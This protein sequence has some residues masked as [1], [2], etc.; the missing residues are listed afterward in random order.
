MN[1]SMIL[2]NSAWAGLFAGTLA[3]LFAS[4]PQYL[5]ATILCGF[6]G[7]CVND[8][9]VAVGL[10]QNLSTAM[11]ACA[12]VLVAAAVTRNHDA[13]PVVL[14]AGVVPLGAALAMFNTI[15]ALMKISSLSGEA[16]NASSVALS[17]NAGKVFTGS[18]A[19]SLGLAAGMAVVR[20]L[21]RREIRTR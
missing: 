21:G 16:L 10:D 12:V 14:A 13:S 20:L 9:L 4:P 15:I 5:P 7:R 6:G 17:A 11:A 3:I 19:I 18:L 2:I 8:V 1:P